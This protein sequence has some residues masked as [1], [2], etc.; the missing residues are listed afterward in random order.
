MMRKI[1]L[2]LLLTTI[3]YGQSANYNAAATGSLDLSGLGTLKLPITGGGTQCVQ[4][5]NSGVPSG[6]G[7][8]CGTGG[9]GANP[10]GFY[11]VNQSTSEPANAINLGALSSG[12]LTC[13]TTTGVCTVATVAAPA[14]AVVGTTDVQ[15]LTNK[16]IS[17]TEINSGLVG[18]TYGGTGVNNGSNTITLAGNLLFTGAFN[19]TFAIPSTSTW[20]FPSGGGSLALLGSTMTGTWNGTT[21]AAAHGGTGVANTATLTL[22]TSN[23]NWATLGTG[24]VKNTTTTG[25]LSNAA[26]SDVY[27]LWTGS[28][29]SS[30]FLRGDG[31][32]AA[33]SGTGN[34]T[35]TSLTT[36]HLSKANGA[37]SII[38]SSVVDN[39]T[40]VSTTEAF[41]AASVSTGTSPPSV[42]AGTGGVDAYG[43]G[44]VPS[45]GAASGVDIC[46]ADSTQH[47]MLCSWNNGSYLPLTQGPASDTSGDLASFSGTGG[48]LLV[49]SGVVAANVT[50]NSSNYTSGHV[51]SANGNH[52]A[53]DSG[54]VAANLVVASSPG[55]GVAHFAGSTQTVTSSAVTPSDATGNTSG[56][57]NFALV[58][59]PVL[60][61]PH[62]TTIDD[63]NGN[64][65]M[66]SSA[67]ASAVDSL[68]V[69]NAATA[70]P[71]VVGLGAT[72]SDSNI[73]LNLQSKGSG[74]V[75]VNGSQ[76]ETTFL[77]T[78]NVWVGVANVAT[79]TAQSSLNVGSA[80]TA[81]TATNIAG[82]A[83]NDIVIQGGTGGT[84]FVT[85][86]N[87]AAVIA[88]SS[89]VP[90][91]SI[92]P[93]LGV[94]GT[95]TGTWAFGNATGS[96]TFT[97]GASP[98]TTSNTML[99]PTS[100]PATGD[101]LSCT[102]SSTTCTLT[103]SGKVAANI[104][105]TTD[106]GS[107]TSTMLA[108]SIANA[109]LSNSSVTVNGTVCTL[110][111]SCSEVPT[112][113]DTAG[114]IT[115]GHLACYTASN[116]IGNCV[117][118]PSNNI[119]GIFN[120]SST[121]VATGETSVVID[122]TQNVT[123]GDILCASSTAGLAH[124][125][126]SVSCTTGEG[127]GVVK[128]TASSVSTV[129]AFVRL[130]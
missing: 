11:L 38:D 46:Y 16:S 74:T 4:V 34:T 23:Q 107:V 52:T 66:T 67:T 86:V 2:T 41:T 93:T 26:S 124:D 116:T 58:T 25:A 19:P 104:V 96:G 7:S 28:C 17:G 99:G 112:F 120:S 49:D 27:G 61:T 51:I 81:A 83:A 9:G 77:S 122:A 102:T 71:A 35:S 85:P 53:T 63:G 64:P 87:G 59:S 119:L 70:N 36:N 128:T 68:T 5:N 40:T 109:K 30:T 55:A 69:T 15:T 121:W 105:S 32:C 6:T 56:S 103:D 3:A 127:V 79:S 100:V 89:G 72:G 90:L 76:V 20:T 33:P 73:S 129:T 14:G 60:T 101:L 118:T 29:S 78:G 39:G 18:A 50:T 130:Y 125:N 115:S 45:V 43:E 10:N 123:F 97:V 91:E 106:T 75:Q 65:F 88:N 82:G 24:I 37:N 80:T 92:T 84:T 31:A 110:G 95:S 113:T 57:G 42:T 111:A 54:V 62:V 117:G 8:V 126:G 48:G 13:S 21:I 12:L 98:S 108:G 44:T 94:P 47:G 22:G 114:T 1:L